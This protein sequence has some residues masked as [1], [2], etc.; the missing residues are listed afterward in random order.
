[1]KGNKVAAV[2]TSLHEGNET[3]SG[4]TCRPQTCFDLASDYSRAAGAL[5]G[6]LLAEAGPPELLTMSAWAPIASLSS[7]GFRLHPLTG[8]VVSTCA[9]VKSR[10][11]SSCTATGEEIYATPSSH[12]VTRTMPPLL[13]R[14]PRG[15]RALRK[16]MRR[17]PVEIGS[18][19]G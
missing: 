19:A 15:G 10:S 17:R 14:I 16:A 2:L 4:N 8:V 7:M 18:D 1:M 11:T 5:A 13:R 12:N 6:G 3:V 9:K